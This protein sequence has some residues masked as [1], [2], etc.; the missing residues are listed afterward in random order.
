MGKDNYINTSPFIA[1]FKRVTTLDR[2]VKRHKKISESAYLKLTNQTLYLETLS[3]FFAR[4][5][6]AKTTTQMMPMKLGCLKQ[7]IHLLLNR[8]QKKI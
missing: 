5:G 8:F 1:I 7:I 6:L 2:K 4:Q 3:V